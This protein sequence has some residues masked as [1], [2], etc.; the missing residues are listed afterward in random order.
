MFM[1]LAGIP[2][3]GAAVIPST[4]ARPSSSL[5][6]LA[7]A[8][9]LSTK[10]LARRVRC[11]CVC[12]SSL[13]FRLHRS[14]SARVMRRRRACCFRLGHGVFDGNRAPLGI[15]GHPAGFQNG[16]GHERGA[17]LAIKGV[18]E[19]THRTDTS[20]MSLEKTRR[21]FKSEGS[22]DTSKAEKKCESQRH[23]KP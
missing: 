8:T 15:E 3:C 4:R 22:V 11:A 13:G 12:A 6:L 20:G 16:R 2:F 18:W 10:A 1:L 23:K 5:T 21:N 17:D 9:C 19:H 14:R 7:S